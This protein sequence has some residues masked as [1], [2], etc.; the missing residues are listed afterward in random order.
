MAIS[1]DVSSEKLA[2]VNDS[3]RAFGEGETPSTEKPPGDE[4]K[5][6]G[7]SSGTLSLS[8]SQARDVFAIGSYNNTQINNFANPEYYRTDSIVTLSYDSFHKSLISELDQLWTNLFF[9]SA[10]V[11]RLAEILER[12]RFLV[13]SGEPETGKASLAL[14]LAACLRRHGRSVKEVLLC[15]HLAENIKVDFNSL[16]DNDERFRDCFLIFTDAFASGNPDLLRF[17]SHLVEAELRALTEHLEGKGAFL[18]WT[19]DAQALPDSMPYLESVQSVPSPSIE[20]LVEGLKY[21]SDRLVAS[22]H[23]AGN[24]PPDE[25]RHLI[26]ERGSFIAGE[27]K[28]MPLIARLVLYLP[29]IIRHQVT[30]EEALERLLTLDQW[31]LVELPENFEAWCTLLALSL[32]STT[33]TPQSI[34]WFQFAHLRK[35]LR[36]F[37][38]RELRQDQKERALRELCHDRRSLE[39]ARA[40]M[41]LPFHRVKFLD[42]RFAEQV[43]ESLLRKGQDLLTLLLPLLHKLLEKE[44]LYSRWSAARALGRIGEIDPLYIVEPLIERCMEAR[45]GELLGQLFQGIIGFKDSDYRSKYLGTLRRLV[46]SP[47][48]ATAATALTSLW[49]VALLDFDFAVTAMKDVAQR[50]I[51]LRLKWFFKQAEEARNIE[52]LIRELEDPE[53]ISD[54]IRRLHTI[55]KEQLTKEIVSPETH[56]LLTVLRDTLTALCLS[57]PDEGLLFGHL[58]DWMKSDPE[59][60]GPLVAFLFLDEGGL[61]TWL[62]RLSP[63]LHSDS[64]AQTGSHLLQSARQNQETA[65]TLLGFLD[66]VFVNLSAFPGV[67][68]HFLQERF[69]SLLAAWAREGRKIPILRPVVVGLLAGLFNSRDGELSE[70][71]LKLA[72]ESATA[73]ASTDLRALAIEAV[74]GKRST[75]PGKSN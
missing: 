75:P 64:G 58:L 7:S 8:N 1:P 24:L 66:Q 42:E 44:D 72:Q 11:E 6:L 47:H 67:F 69:L 53:E 31:L 52:Q 59:Q 22:E 32:C 21:L 43:W 10:Q 37:F 51:R 18:I 48:P 15:H 74:L 62:E 33:P 29:A 63:N 12:Q 2:K 35:A 56:L 39:Q 71:I 54:T 38:R 49:Q 20:H 41:I 61:A 34:P 36:K 50:R 26:E 46:T 30:L 70:L 27:L 25:V 4:K 45:D 16:C 60:L 17:T 9:D 55:A 19:T 68:R 57:M 23:L 40:E 13:L 3:L 73:S 14:L 65:R 5:P 28:T